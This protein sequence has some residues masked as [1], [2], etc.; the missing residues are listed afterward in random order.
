MPSQHTSGLAENTPTTGWPPSRIKDALPI[1]AQAK[2][3]RRRRLSYS[4][5]S[6]VVARR[7]RSIRVEESIAQIIGVPREEIFGPYTRPGRKT[8]STEVAA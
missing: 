4:L 3:A 5:I 2:I 7:A 8:P 6:K 1:G